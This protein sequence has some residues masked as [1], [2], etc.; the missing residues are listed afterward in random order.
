MENF[1]LRRAC[2]K[3]HRDRL[4]TVI[5]ATGIRGNDP[6][7]FRVI[8]EACSNERAFLFLSGDD[9]VILRP[10]INQATYLELL[11]VAASNANSLKQYTPHLITIANSIEA[12]YLEFLTFRKG[13]FR[14]ATKIG[15]TLTDVNNERCTWRYYIGENSEQFKQSRRD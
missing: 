10:R 9:F 7:I 11:F 3:E 2:W 15:W 14:T 12:K 4:R 8:D 6:N 13:F 1:P 5:E